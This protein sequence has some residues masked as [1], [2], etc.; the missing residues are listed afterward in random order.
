[1]CILHMDFMNHHDALFLAWFLFSL[2]FV[3]LTPF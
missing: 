2:P 1:M 3:E